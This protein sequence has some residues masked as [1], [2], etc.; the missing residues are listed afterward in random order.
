IYVDTVDKTDSVVTELAAVLSNNVGRTDL[1]D[2]AN[3]VDMYL[4][5][6]MVNDAY[7]YAA[8]KVSGDSAE[9]SFERVEPYYGVLDTMF[10]DIW[11]E[12]YSP[13]SV[14]SNFRNEIITDW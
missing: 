14:W 5:Y 4:L 10:N 11:L 12:S 2:S 6:N 3:L 13:T 7:K 9:S 8:F 1:M